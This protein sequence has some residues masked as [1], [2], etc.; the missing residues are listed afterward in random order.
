MNTDTAVSFDEARLN[1]RLE[2]LIRQFRTGD[3]ASR[4]RAVR[5]L[6]ALGIVAVPA[7]VEALQDE[8]WPVRYHAASALGKIKAFDAI[9]AL[10]SVWKD[11]HET[12]WKVR[13]RAGQSLVEIGS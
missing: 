13:E 4:R 8:Y 2:D 5:E 9:P 6:I 7:L 12:Y 10:V 11:W 3:S 1:Q